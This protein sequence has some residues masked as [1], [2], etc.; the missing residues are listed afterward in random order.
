MAPPAGRVTSP[1]CTEDVPRT[2]RLEIRPQGQFGSEPPALLPEEG[3][4]GGR[5]ACTPAAPPSRAS[6]DWGYPRLKRDDHTLSSQVFAF[7][8]SSRSI[9]F[10]EEV[11]QMEHLSPGDGMRSG[12]RSRLFLS[13]GCGRPGGASRGGSP[14][15][16]T[17]ALCREPPH[18]AAPSLVAFLL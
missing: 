6:R 7:S 18:P 13:Q 1:R 12:A 4:G 17:E 9:T 3:G 8:K 10:G 15:G 2:A 16:C 11:L 5:A 14:L